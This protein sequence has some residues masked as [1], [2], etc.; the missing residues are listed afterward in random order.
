MPR[1]QHQLGLSLVVL[2]ATAWSTA[3]Y[4]IRILPYDSWTIL[5]WRLASAGRTNNAWHAAALLDAA[6]L[7]FT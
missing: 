1:S 5:F 3:P 6:I 7:R 2:A 4:F